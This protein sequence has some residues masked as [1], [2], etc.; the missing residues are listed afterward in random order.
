MCIRDRA[1]TAA[2]GEV[3]RGGKHQRHTLVRDIAGDARRHLILVTATPHSGNEE[4]FRSLLEFLSPSFAELPDDLSGSANEAKPVSYT[5]LRA[6][7]T[8][9]DLVCRLLLANKQ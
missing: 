1:H 2:F 6:H 9:L 7:E 4:A 8:V 3:G 5:H